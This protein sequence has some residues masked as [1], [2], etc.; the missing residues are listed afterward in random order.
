MAEVNDSPSLMRSS[1]HL[2]GTKEGV[3]EQKQNTEDPDEGADFAVAT[4][5]ELDE[6]EG[7]QTEAK[8]G[9]DTERQRRGNEGE[10]GG[11]GFAEIIPLDSGHGAAHERA[12]K[13]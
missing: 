7:E 5:S 13:D 8:P 2:F 10:E 3:A 11:E 4:G 1:L 12:D 6:G 9:S